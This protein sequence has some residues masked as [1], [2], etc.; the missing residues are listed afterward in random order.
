MY[1]F[2]AVITALF[3]ALA[4]GAGISAAQEKQL[5][6]QD[7]QFMNKA[8]MGSMMEV[9]LG[10]MAQE[11]ASSQDVKDFGQTMVQDHSK[12]NQKLKDIAQENNVSL[13][14]ELDAKHRRTV[15]ELSSLEGESFDRRYMDKMV[16]D[17]KK[18]IDTFQKEVQQGQHPEV[19][20]FASETLDTLQQ[21]H[22]MAQRIEK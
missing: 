1:R 6:E 4:L 7:R 20:Q 2:T 11:K 18:D 5:S 12:A 22:E 15:D 17:H 13:P 14:Q 9:Q 10:K 21:H 8:A 3:L 19:T 16:E